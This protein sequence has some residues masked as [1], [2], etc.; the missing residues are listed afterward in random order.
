MNQQSAHRMQNISSFLVMDLLQRAKQLEQEGK[1]IIHM[2]IGEPDF[3]TPAKIVEAAQ[4]FLRTGNIKY[5]PAAG[6][7]ELRLAIAS[8]YQK[9]YSLC[10]DPRRIIITPGASGA[11]LLA[12]G[13]SLNA[14]QKIIMADPCYPCNANF[15]RFFDAQTCY[16][17]VEADT[18]YQ[19]NAKLIAENWQESTRGVLIASP[20]N[21]S[22]T[23]INGDNL[24]QSIQ[25]VHE[26]N[27]CFYSDE[28]Y[29]GL[30]YQGKAVTA[31]TYSDE[32][33]IINSFSKFFGMTGWRIGWL[34][35][36]EAFITSAEKLAQN[37][38]IST[39]TLAQFAALAAFSEEN[40]N[41]LL[42]RRDDFRQRR[43]FLWENLPKLGF[44]LACKPEGAFYIYADCSA[45]S[46]D[47]FDFANQLLEAE[48]VAITPGQDFGTFKAETHIRFAYTNS[49]DRMATALNRVERF[50][51]R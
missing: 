48:G 49:I 18:D 13:S 40:M 6:L 22:G 44:K 19:L 17:A 12:F 35:V 50:I 21:P 46:H 7:P 31:L 37:L 51:C 43:D 38:F 41:E 42:K 14:G 28:I 1:D 23:L 45:I 29:H 16:V 36:P 4:T 30:V 39:S 10:I 27:G 3:P 15:V 9:E 20:A 47:S 32:V 11:F 26:L 5:T 34:V 8:Y 33:F 25:L 2:E 24:E